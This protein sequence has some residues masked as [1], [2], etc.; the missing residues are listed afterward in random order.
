MKVGIQPTGSGTLLSQLQAAKKGDLYISADDGNIADAKSKQLIRE[1]L[2]LV[3]Q[4][5]VVVVKKGNSK[6]I[7]ALADLMKAD[8]KP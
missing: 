1:V 3:T 8:G 7:H 4:H 2:P 5:P 6:G